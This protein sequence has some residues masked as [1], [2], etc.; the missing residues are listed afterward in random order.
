MLRRLGQ[1]TGKLKKQQQIKSNNEE[2]S[3]IFFV[4]VQ[5]CANSETNQTGKKSTTNTFRKIFFFVLTLTDWFY[6]A[7]RLF[8]DRSHEKK[9]NVY[10]VIYASVFQLIISKN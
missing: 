4:T 1:K 7:L 6:F 8:C 3:I 5:F 2:N 10:D 9:K